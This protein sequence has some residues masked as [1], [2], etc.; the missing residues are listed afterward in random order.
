MNK[1]VLIEKSIPTDFFFASPE[2]SAIICN[3]T[4]QNDV[5]RAK[6]GG[7]GIYLTYDDAKN[8][9]FFDSGEEI[10]SVPKKDMEKVMTAGDCFCVYCGCNFRKAKENLRLYINQFVYGRQTTT[11]TTPI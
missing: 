1:K 11:T 7:H 8:V 2:Y 5:A 10:L 4:G 3:A 6:T 9:K